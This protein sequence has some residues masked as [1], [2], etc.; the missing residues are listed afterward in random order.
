MG[1]S[2]TFDCLILSVFL[3]FVS[4]GMGAGL[5]ETR[6]VY[7]NW[8]KEAF[9]ATLGAKLISSGQ[10]GAARRFWPF[11]SP[12]ALLLAFLN[13]YLAWQQAGAVRMVW[14]AASLIIIVKSVATYLYFA[15]TMMRS[16]EHATGLE[17]TKLRRMISQWTMLSPLRAAAEFIAWAAGVYALI[18]MA[19]L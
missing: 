17:T 7:P 10:A 13:A 5:Y 9:P 8:A 4:L 1:V 14:L 3:L 16:F 19:R 12:A 18:L 15:P 6:V 11:V 2:M